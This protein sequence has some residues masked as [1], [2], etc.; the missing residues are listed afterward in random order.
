MAY[1]SKFILSYVDISTISRTEDYNFWITIMNQW[2]TPG[3]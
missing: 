2:M 3:F 1:T